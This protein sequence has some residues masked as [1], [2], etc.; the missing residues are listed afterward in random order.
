[1]A[2]PMVL[3]IDGARKAAQEEIPNM[4]REATAAVLENVAKNWNRVVGKV[5]LDDGPGVEMDKLCGALSMAAL[6]AS[7]HFKKIMAGVFKKIAEDNPN[8]TIKPCPELCHFEFV[9]IYNP[10]V[11]AI[12]QPKPKEEKPIEPPKPEVPQVVICT[13]Q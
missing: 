3:S 10:P 6:S 9:P 11:A 4:I 1:M 8:Y 13:S 7:P 12:E 5:T 2:A